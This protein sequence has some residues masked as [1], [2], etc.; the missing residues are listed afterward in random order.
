MSG[1]MS[2]LGGVL[3]G[4]VLEALLFLICINDLDLGILNK[5]L[6]FA[7]DTKIFG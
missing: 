7:D 6:K 3:Q 1:W 4:S 2:I 5:L